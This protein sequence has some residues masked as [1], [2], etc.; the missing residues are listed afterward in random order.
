MLKTLTQSA[1]PWP[2][3]SLWSFRLSGWGTALLRLLPPELAHDLGLRLLRAGITDYFPRPELDTLAVGLKT[4][5]PGLGVLPHPIGLAAGFDKNAYCP[6]GFARLGLSFIE[7][8]TVTP[9]PQSGNPKPRLFRA[10]EERAL[11]NRM[12]FNSD[13]ALA[14]EAR[15]KRLNWDHDA[16]PLGI[17]CGKNKHTEPG[18]AVEDYLQVIETM[19]ERARFFV[20]NISSPNTP[21]LRDLATPEFLQELAMALGPYLPKV[22]VK[23][24]PDRPKRE[25]QELVHSVADQGYLGLVLCNTHRVEHPEPGGQSGHPLMAPSTTCL[26]WAHEVHRGML[27]MLASGGILSGVD[28]FHKLARGASAVQIYTALVYR[29]PLVVY[30]MLYE[31]AEE[32]RLR[33]FACA[34]DAVGSFYHD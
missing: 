18:R 23:L 13:G 14:V 7:V 30:R 3:R 17:N 29:G 28:I 6:Q 31:L 10:P 22:L 20:I 2:R 9:R 34:G 21:G 33:G 25:F 16:V 26:E 15:L 19:R 5:V 24:D 12:G 32:L 11:V 1:G 4:T 27:P 8:G